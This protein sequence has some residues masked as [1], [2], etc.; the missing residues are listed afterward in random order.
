M[1]GGRNNLALDNDKTR[2][3]VPSN[4]SNSSVG[5][6]QHNKPAKGGKIVDK[7]NKGHYGV[8]NNRAK[9]M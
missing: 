2:G 7:T 8:T 4:Q 5:L 3:S 6:V 1:K 9:G